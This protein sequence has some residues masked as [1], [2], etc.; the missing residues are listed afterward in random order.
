M[1]GETDRAVSLLE[2]GISVH[3][4][5]AM[6]YNDLATVQERRG[7]HEAA[8]RTLEHALLEASGLPQLHK[9]LGDYHYRHHRYD[10]A[11][12]AYERVVRL[13]PEHG[14]DVWLKLGNIHYRR[15]QQ[16]QGRAAWERALAIDPSNEIVRGNLGVVAGTEADDDVA[17]D[18]VMPPP[19]SQPA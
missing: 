10:E 14:A 13:A 15:G 19:V 1:R 12:E 17:S 18:R 2:E 6:L 9:N 11:F 5:A 16:D 3:P 8:A 7:L 4:H